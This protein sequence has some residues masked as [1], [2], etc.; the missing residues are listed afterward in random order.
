[1]IIVVWLVGGSSGIAIL[2]LYPLTLLS[3]GFV[4]TKMVIIPL[5]VF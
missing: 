2:A 4:V 5:M 1:M 3:K